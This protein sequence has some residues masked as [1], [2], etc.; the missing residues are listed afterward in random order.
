MATSSDLF[1]GEASSVLVPDDEVSSI[2]GEASSRIPIET[3]TDEISSAL[4]STTAK[5]LGTARDEETESQ[6]NLNTA[7]DGGDTASQTTSSTSSLPSS[8]PSSSEEA[9]SKGGGGTDTGLIAGAAV[10]GFIGLL[11]IL[12]A[13]FFAFRLGKRRGGRNVAETPRKRFRDR[14]GSV[15]RPTVSWSRPHQAKDEE[16]SKPELPAGIDT[17]KAELHGEAK[18]GELLADVQQAPQELEADTPPRR[19]GGRGG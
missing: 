12:A 15:P 18:P 16:S 13:I 14:L 1:I 19:T 9:G 11:L 17:Q 4:P 10:G 2:I 8:D 7:R 3:L 5:N 6:T